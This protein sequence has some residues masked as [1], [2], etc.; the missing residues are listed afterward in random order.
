MT[1]TST[2]TSCECKSGYYISKPTSGEIAAQPL[3]VVDRPG[4]CSICSGCP[5]CTGWVSADGY[6]C[7]TEYNN[8]TVQHVEGKHE[9]KKLETDK[10]YYFGSKV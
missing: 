7:H 2:G 4:A 8:K 9:C 1:V 6:S 10:Y 3:I 5:E